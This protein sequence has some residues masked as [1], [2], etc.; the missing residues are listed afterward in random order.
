VLDLEKIV[1]K[2]SGR[3]PE[4]ARPRPA[5]AHGKTLGTCPV[6][7]RPVV[8]QKKSF[9]CSG[10]REGCQFVIWK[11]IAGKRI[12]SRTAETLL[13]NGVTAQLK[14]FKS[15]AGKPFEAR[16]RIANNAVTIEF[17]T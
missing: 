1:A 11:T 3:K 16:L 14:G 10:W 8:E 4:P 5:P 12:T 7:G 6:C 17:S 2:Y 13:K 15:K 9:S